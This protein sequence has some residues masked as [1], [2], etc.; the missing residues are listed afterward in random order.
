VESAVTAMKLGALEFLKKPL[1]SPDA[2][3]RAVT[4][5]SER[6]KLRSRV[7]RT[8]MSE[9][10]N[11][12]QLTFSAPS[13]RPVV[14]ALKKVA[15]TNA[16][17]LL[18][19]ESGTGKEV[20][21]RA[22]HFWSARRPG[23]FVAINC[24]ALTESLLESELFGYER[25]AFSGAEK[26]RIGRI[27]QAQGGTFFLDEVGELRPD[28]QAKLLRVLQERRI[29]RLGGTDSIAVDVRWIAAT[30]RDLSAAMARGLFREDL[31][32]R[33]A[34]FPVVLPPLRERREDIVPL[35]ERLLFAI[36]CEL[37][38]LG[39]SLD[40]SAKAFLKGSD[41]PG[42]VRELRNTLERAAIVSEGM[43][44]TAA[45]LSAN[46]LHGRA[47]GKVEAR[48]DAPLSGAR[49][50][51]TGAP[52]PA[53][54][55]RGDAGSARDAGKTLEQTEREAIERALAAHGG[56]RKKTAEALGISLRA[57]YDKLKRYGLG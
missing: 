10:L 54:A 4:A 49:A 35:A 34:V 25:G 56:H 41:W 44:I 51:S 32:H 5:A 6:Y 48:V 50:G 22:L 21:A 20:T 13:M 28:I 36:S 38:R 19:G 1:E 33:L 45:A 30:N 2:L 40:E 24:A 17:V 8:T 39:L 53:A 37:G 46:P 52:T 3:V 23:P 14:E 57:L 26:R 31:F 27:E 18:L 9:A 16:T 12:P 11:A 29:Q 42:N 15:S 47:E 55:S 7:E 43:V